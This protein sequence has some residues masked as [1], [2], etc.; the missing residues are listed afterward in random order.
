M[1]ISVVIIAFNE[2]KNLP[3]T[4]AA[5][6]WAD[7]ILLVDSDSTD[8]T[9]AIARAAGARVINQPFLGYGPQKAFA[10][11]HA[12]HNWVFV[13]DAD[14]VVSP[15]LAA[16]VQ[17]V[18]YSDS[19]Y[20]GYRVPRDFVFLGRLMRWGGERGKSHLRLFNRLH[21]NYNDASVHEDVVLNGP[22]G[23]LKHLMLHYSYPDLETYWHKF[24]QYTTRGA[25]DLF[26]RG[27]NVSALYVMVR[28]P[29]SFLYLY[30]VRGLLLDGYPGFIWAFFSAVYPVV[31]YAKL[32]E[33]HRV[34]AQK[35]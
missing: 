24:N 14:E 29:F 1:P 5:L 22:V 35:S 15:E 21:G 8:D 28:F 4:L 18:V 7:E 26:K 10:V 32:R 13:V 9:V 12:S 31:K 20:V 19:K 25:Q 34:A 6:T 16:E 11:N 17:N 33:L 27:K 23:Q 30:L 3:R 2:A